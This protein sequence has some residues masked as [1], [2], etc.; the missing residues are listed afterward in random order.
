VERG[1]SYT[2]MKQINKKAKST[3]RFTSKFAN[4]T[5]FLL[6]LFFMFFYV[7]VVCSNMAAFYSVFSPHED[8]GEVYSF[9]HSETDVPIPKSLPDGMSD[10]RKAMD[11]NETIDV[12]KMAKTDIFSYNVRPHPVTKRDIPMTDFEWWL[13]LGKGSEV[14]VKIGVVDGRNTFFHKARKEGEWKQ[15]AAAPPTVYSI[16]LLHLL[17]CVLVE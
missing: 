10:I 11:D 9:L 2:I 8:G 5:S 13:Q 15:I 17:N 12:L 6:L 4:V 7:Q 1:D 3:S 14:W 16:C